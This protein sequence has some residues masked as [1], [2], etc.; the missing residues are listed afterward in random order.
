M[1]TGGFLGLHAIGT[2]GVLF[3]K[4]YAGFQVAIPVGLLVSAVF[5]AA[6]AFVD[7]RPEI[8]AALIR[9][10]ALLRFAVLITMGV[11]LVWTVV[12]L[13]PLRG[14]GSE[15]ATDTLVA[16]MAVIG[17][18]VYAVSAARYWTIFRHH[19]DLLPVATIACVLLLSEAMIGVAVTG[20]RKWHASWW[21]WHGLIVTAYLIIGFAARREWRDERFRRLYLSTTRERHQDISILFGD[22]VGFTSFAERATPAEAAAVLNAYWSVAAPLITRQFGGEVEKFIGNGVVASFNS[23]GDQA[24]HALRAARAALALQ[25]RLAGLTEEHPDW[26]RMRVGVNS[27]KAVVRE[28]G[29]DGHVAYPSVGDTVNTGARLESLAP[30]GGV[31]IGAKTYEQLPDGTLVEEPAGLRIKG[32]DDVVNAYV[33]LALP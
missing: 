2:A 29:A 19:R 27:G 26:P 32:K 15:A 10:R 8:G 6:S 17:T 4:E 28:I 1:A 7:V 23:R 14:S 33:L 13:P 20:E 21:E 5:A 9:R 12:E 11:W 3:S 30:P 18:I 31:L 25:R 24:D 22:L 16:V